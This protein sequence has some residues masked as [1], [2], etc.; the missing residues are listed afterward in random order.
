MIGVAAAVQDL[1]GSCLGLIHQPLDQDDP[2]Q[3]QPDNTLARE[4]LN[5]EAKVA[6]REGLWSTIACIGCCRSFCCGLSA[7]VF[8]PVAYHQN[9]L[10]VARGQSDCALPCGPRAIGKYW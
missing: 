8:V 9:G 4:K 3:W 7:E 2:R 6:L 5:W 1:T 10:E